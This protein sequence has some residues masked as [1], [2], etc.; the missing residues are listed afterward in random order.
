MQ[1]SYAVKIY[2]VRQ[3]PYLSQILTDLKNPFAVTFS[4][5][6][7]IRWPSS[8]SEVTRLY[9]SFIVTTWCVW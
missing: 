3:C 2:T 5:K 4:R 1:Q 6:F 9:R 8:A 7:A